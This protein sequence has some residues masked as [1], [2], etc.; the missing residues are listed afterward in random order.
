MSWSVQAIGKASA[1][2]AKLAEEFGKNPCVQPEEAVRQGAG[3][4]IDISLESMADMIVKVTASGHQ[5]NTYD[6]GG[7][8]KAIYNQLNVSIEPLHGF[9]E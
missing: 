3:K 2:R 7:K 9:I 8:T 6:Q 1:V 5:G 4:T